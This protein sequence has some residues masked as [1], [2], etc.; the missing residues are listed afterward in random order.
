VARGFRTIPSE[1]DDVLAK[2][3]FTDI[4]YVKTRSILDAL[5]LGQADIGAQVIAEILVS[6]ENDQR[7]VVL[8]GLHGGCYELFGTDGVRAIRDLKS[9][10]V[11]IPALG[12]GRHLILSAMAAHVGLDPAKDINWVA[13]PAR[14]SMRLLA[15][16]N[17]DA[18]LAFPPETQEMRA[19][20]IGHLVVSMTT[21]R[22]WKDYFC[23]MVIARRDFV[24]KSPIAAKRAT[25]A[26]LKATSICTD[27]PA[28][29][30]RILVDRGF[31]TEYDYTLQMAKELAYARW[32]SYD[33]DASLRF[34]ALRLQEAGL[35]KSSPQKLLARGTDWRFLNELKRELKG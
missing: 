27:D 20:K 15:E 17:V 12:A 2:D 10:R 1:S 4:Q 8:T 35:I 26:I 14:E 5:H 23:C 6:I 29:A 32:R 34:Y 7:V 9:W 30:A 33:P 22:P 31:T 24:Q 28:R 25:R 16:G 11:A 3:R 19:K 18:F 13:Q 21:D